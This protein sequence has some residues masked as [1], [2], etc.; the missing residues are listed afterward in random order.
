MG[1][2]DTGNLPPLFEVRTKDG[3]KYVVHPNGDVEGFGEDV[4]VCNWFD[5]WLK[6][7]CAQQV[8]NIADSQPPSPAANDS[9]KDDVGAGHSIPLYPS[10][11][12]LAIATAPGEK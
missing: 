7:C 9:L 3:R 6:Y 10:I 1:E 11:K 2:I 5:W 12:S 8:G 4:F